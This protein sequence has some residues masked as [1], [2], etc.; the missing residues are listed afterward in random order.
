MFISVKHYMSLRTLWTWIIGQ[1]APEHSYQHDNAF[2]SSVVS[3]KWLT[4]IVIQ[5]AVYIS[6][7]KV[8]I[9][10][11]RYP[12]LII[13]TIVWFWHDGTLQGIISLG[14]IVCFHQS[15]SRW[16]NGETGNYIHIIPRPNYS[17]CLA[18]FS[19]HYSNFEAKIMNIHY[20]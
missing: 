20:G 10:I 14:Y 16:G 1:Y 13:P 17:F 2:M 12:Q 15:M 18:H 4:C 19:I 5:S 6:H 11:N 8:S 7:L 9:N 3:Y